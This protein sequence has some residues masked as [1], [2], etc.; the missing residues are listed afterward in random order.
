MTTTRMVAGLG[1]GS[2]VRVSAHVKVHTKGG[3]D[4]A[5]GA[6]EIRTGRAKMDAQ[7]RY[8]FRDR[9][10]ERSGEREDR[11]DQGQDG[12]GK[13]SGGGGGGKRRK[14]GRGRGV[15]YDQNKNSQS[16]DMYH[17]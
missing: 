11:A 17:I 14:T 9:H 10:D 7:E 8:D 4:G 15:Y 12:S 16:Y 1:G 3:D 13:A 2:G 6:Q 5:G